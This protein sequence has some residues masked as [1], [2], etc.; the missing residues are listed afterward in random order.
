MPVEIAYG[1]RSLRLRGLRDTG[2]GLKDPV[3]G[4]SVLVVGAEAAQALTGLTA[5]QLARP[6]ENLGAIPGLRLIPYRT[7]GSR[8][9]LLGMQLQK[10]RIGSRK[11]SVVVAF[12]PMGLEGNV[13]A[14]IGGWV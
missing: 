14:L 4:R 8:G 6:L 10:V 9:F 13:E 7:V 5:Q 1:G 12:A 11:G 3:S 2:N